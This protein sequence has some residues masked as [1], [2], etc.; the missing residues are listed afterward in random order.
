MDPMA[1]IFEEAKRNPEMKKKLKVKAVFSMLLLVA[2]LGVVFITI[3]TF[4]SGR[5]GTFL[6]MTRLDFLKLRAHYGLFMMMLIFI[7]LFMNKGIISKEVDLL[8]G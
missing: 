2:F 4:L 3:G 8:R 7:H 5:H 6:G 1:K